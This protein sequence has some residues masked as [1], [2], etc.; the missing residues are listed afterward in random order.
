MLESPAVSDPP[1]DFRILFGS[2][3]MGVPIQTSVLPMLGYIYI[4]KLLVK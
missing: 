3:N 4:G 2:V 1:H